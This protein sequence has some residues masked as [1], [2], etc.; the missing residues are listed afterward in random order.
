M[1]N[2]RRGK[3]GN[4][5]SLID[6]FINYLS[7]EKGC[8]TH[9]LDAYS[10]DLARLHEFLNGDTGRFTS[11]P[12]GAARGFIH[13]LRSKSRLS[14]Q[15]I[16]RN[17]AALKSFYSFL[18][19]E[20]IIKPENFVEIQ[21]YPAGKRLPRALAQ[22]EIARIIESEKGKTPK[23]IRNR[24]ILE[25]LYATGMRVSEL[26]SLRLGDYNARTGF[27]RCLGKGKK[28]RFTPVGAE[29]KKWLEKYIA[30]VRPLYAKPGATH[31]FLS[32]RGSKIS[33]ESC[34]R[35]LR[36]CAAKAGVAAPVSPHSF[37]HSFATHLLENGADVRLIQELLGHSSIATTQHY[38][39]LSLRKI[40]ET[41]D[42]CHPRAGTDKP[43]PP[44]RNAN[45]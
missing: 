17:V 41:Y 5:D 4:L 19:R 11:S 6:D 2:T 31:V 44:E 39:H 18:C 33:R 10:R 26:T 8:S 28:T 20:G 42:S 30:E 16:A 12:A 29:A 21:S 9:T 27:A 37:R 24:A 32:P 23:S 43:C 35:L 25:L 13:H 36:S 34:W 3:T 22:D 40:K 7:V 15:S 1:N 45:S 38:T 14:D